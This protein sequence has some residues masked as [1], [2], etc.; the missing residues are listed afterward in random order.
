MDFTKKINSIN[1]PSA[2]K[3]YSWFQDNSILLLSV[4]WYLLATIAKTSLNKKI[5]KELFDNLNLFQ[6]KEIE[7]HR[8]PEYW[9]LKITSLKEK[10][11]N[12]ILSN[13]RKVQTNQHHI[14]P[15]WNW[16]LVEVENWII[17]YP[18]SSMKSNLKKYSTV[19]SFLT[20]RIRHGWKYFD[21]SMKGRNISNNIFE[22]AYQR[23]NNWLNIRYPWNLIPQ[24]QFWFEWYHLDH[25][26]RN[27]LMSEID[28]VDN[29]LRLVSSNFNEFHNPDVYCIT[30][31]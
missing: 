5:I 3:L 9:K 6:K 31:K 12:W 26:Y 23:H 15:Q 7:I 13:D 28:A 21:W 2:P 10:I 25:D 30:K 8:S 14:V 18:E 16:L 1:L 29:I 22:M 27:L 20:T 17:K 19:L 4:R 24:H 11:I